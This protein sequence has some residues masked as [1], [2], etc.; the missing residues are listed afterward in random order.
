MNISMSCRNCSISC[1]KT[2]S[3]VKN[4]SERPESPESIVYVSDTLLDSDLSQ[5]HFILSINKGKSNKIY[6]HLL[7]KIA[8][9]KTVALYNKGTKIARLTLNP[10]YPLHIKIMATSAP[11]MPLRTTDN[12]PSLWMF[13]F[14]VMNC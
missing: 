14:Q 11:N 3:N 1:I 9:A 2:M 8:D 4:H 6:S 10:V 7:L 12:V 13:T 5:R